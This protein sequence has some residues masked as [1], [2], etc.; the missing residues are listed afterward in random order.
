MIQNFAPFIQFIAAIYV[1]ICCDN[2]WKK[3]FWTPDYFNDF[4]SILKRMGV[5]NILGEEIFLKISELG[6]KRQKKSLLRA[7][8]ML[9]LC[10]LLLL[11]IGFEKC[12]PSGGQASQVCALYA[13]V[14]TAL[15]MLVFHKKT[16]AQW[17]RV[18]A[19]LLI[20]GSVYTIAFYIQLH[21]GVLTVWLQDDSTQTILSWA[22]VVVLV[23][24]I[25]LQLFF[26]WTYSR[27][28]MQHMTY[29]CESHII[30]YNKAK[31][32]KS[33][34]DINVIA[35]R[36]K[37]SV[38]KSV[39]PSGTFDPKVPE[40]SLILIADLKNCVKVPS[41]WSLLRTIIRPPQIQNVSIIVTSV[42]SPAKLD[43]GDTIDMEDKYQKYISRPYKMRMQDFCS[44]EGIALADFNP[45]YQRR[46]AQKK[47]TSQI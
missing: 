19:C 2:L 16:L 23:L 21:T 34:D 15:C 39:Y 4:K 18:I 26:H 1:T 6:D 28:F 31:L 24:P 45:Y 11:Y 20:V 30:E 41:I 40:I 38:I 35:D 27:S 36:Y 29:E 8:F 46:E 47:R 33:G 42:A 37:N 22:I 13:S 32:Y 12:T 25:L 10:I 43:I 5:T 44:K 3:T 9:V 17:R 14:I 7:V